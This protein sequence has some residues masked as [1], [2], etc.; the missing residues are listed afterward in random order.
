MVRT[1]FPTLC[2]IVAVGGL[3]GC[4]LVKNTDDPAGEGG[5]VS[6]APDGDMTRMVEEIWTPRV[7]P[8]L[9][10]N[11]TDFATLGPAIEAD[12]DAAGE[13]HGYRPTSEGTPWN[14]A[15]LVTGTVIA[16]ETDTRAATADVDV[17]GDGTAD[18][19]LQLGPV[20][21][22]TAL[23]DVLAF[24]DFSSFTD[25]IEFAQL[26]RALNTKAYE[27]ALESLS[28]EGLV[29]RKVEAL[30]AFT[31]RGKGGAVLVTPVEIALDEQ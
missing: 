24:V 11:A 28:R 18:A 5:M 10:E 14:F 1:A 25:Q 29:G 15:T 19:V 16:A 23:R 8:Y 20:I 7:L 6:S 26:S 30:G 17:D 22:G 31:V 4:K 9:Q 3:V 12:L 2:L 21:R 27:T 13:A